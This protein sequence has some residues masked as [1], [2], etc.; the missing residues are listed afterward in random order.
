MRTI[1]LGTRKSNLAM[2]QTEWVINELNKRN[3]PYEFETKKIVTKGD[4]ILDVTL[5]K[6]GGK[7]LFIKE[8]EEALIHNEIDI[9]VHSMKDLPGEMEEGFTLGAITNRVDPRDVLISNEDLLLDDLPSGAVVGTSSLR[10]SAQILARR[11]DVDIQWI[12]GNIETRLRKL[13][14]EN[15][16]AIVL[17]AAGLGRMGWDEKIVT[18]YLDP[19]IC[20]PAVGQG[21]LGLECRAD[22]EEVRNVLEELNDELVARRVTAERAFLQEVEGGCQVPIGGY[23]LLEANGDVTLTAMIGSPDG[24]TVLREKK[25][26]SNPLEVGREA[27]QTLLQ[28]GGKEILDKVKSELDS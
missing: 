18:E 21:A 25:T 5:S 3:L 20:L 22:D 2:K 16:D 27:A 11:P 19:D 26:G 7:G 12:R 17:A 23:A 1:V 15:F 10:R 6:V 13:R 8:I 4:K 9:A 28:R 14:E 24:A